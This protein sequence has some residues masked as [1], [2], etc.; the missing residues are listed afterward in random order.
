MFNSLRKLLR[1]TLRQ[2]LEDGVREALRRYADLR[3]LSAMTRSSFT[4]M[5]WSSA[6]FSVVSLPAC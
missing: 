4:D 6:A 1:P 2:Q 5:L 3:L